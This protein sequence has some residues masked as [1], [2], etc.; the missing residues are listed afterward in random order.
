MEKNPAYNEDDEG[1]FYWGREC[2]MYQ[3]DDWNSKPTKACIYDV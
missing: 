1:K 2:K 3:L